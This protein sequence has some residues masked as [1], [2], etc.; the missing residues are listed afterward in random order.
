MRNNYIFTIIFVCLTF[1]QCAAQSKKEQIKVLNTSLDSLKQALE[2]ET[3]LTIQLETKLSQLAEKLEK[4]ET[5]LIKSNNSLISSNKKTSELLLQLNL[6]KD[7]I[8]IYRNSITKLKSTRDFSNGSFNDDELNFIIEYFKRELKQINDEELESKLLI[9]DVEITVHSEGELGYVPA[10]YFQRNYNKL[11]AGD[12]D[13]DGTPEIIFT[14]GVTGGGTAHWGEIYCLKIFSNNG[15]ILF[16]IEAPCDCRNNYE[17][18]EP[19]TAI[20]NVQE[21]VLTIE[22][23]CFLDSDANCCPSSIIK[24]KYKFIDKSLLLI[25]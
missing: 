6:L 23:H 4:K 15:Y 25:N 3:K 24:S 11:L 10:F 2:Q 7:S 17:C 13:N 8:E 18:R 20:L 19:N 5:E 9:D 1:I 16:N 22:T 21:N 14:V 12:L